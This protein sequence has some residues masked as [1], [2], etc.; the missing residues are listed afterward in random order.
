MTFV[1]IIQIN[2]DIVDDVRRICQNIEA[3]D[4]SFKWEINGYNLL[5]SHE[6]NRNKVYARVVW[7][8]NKVEPLKGCKFRVTKI[9]QSQN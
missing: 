4:S 2:P 7:L 6:N 8:I 5:I 1:G 3:K 9:E